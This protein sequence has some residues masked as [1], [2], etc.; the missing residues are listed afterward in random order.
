MAAARATI[1]ATP[2]AAPTRCYRS[3]GRGKIPSLPFEVRVVDARPDAGGGAV[4]REVS[5]GG[6]DKMA[7]RKTAAMARRAALAATLALALMLAPLTGRAAAGAPP[8]LRVIMLPALMPDVIA[9][10]LPIEFTPPVSGAPVLNLVAAVWCGATNNGGAD[11]IGV[12]YPA[13]APVRPAPAM[14]SEDCSRPLAEVARR[15]LA[16][17]PAPWLEAVRVR[18]TWRPWRLRL[19]LADAAGAARTGAVAPNLAAAPIAREFA[20]SNMRLLTGAGANAAFDVAIGF[21]RRAVDVVAIPAGRVSNPEPFLDDPDIAAQISGAPP[22]SNLLA[23]ATYTFI[24]QVLRLYGA[25]FPVPI[26]I[27]GVNQTMIARDLAVTGGDRFMTASGKLAYQSIEYDAAVRCEG[28]A[29]AVSKVTIDAPGATCDQ[30]DLLAR[31]RCQGGGLAMAESG[32]ALANALTNYYAGQPLRL[33]SRGNPLRFS[34]AGAEFLA[35]FDALKASSLGGTLREAGHA[36]L[37]RVSPP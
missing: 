37:R 8:P 4:G 6:R 31:M 20:T 36:R 35:T 28:D 3:R 16:G 30:S 10:A 32:G 29:L 33:S 12:V 18:A 7:Y 11:A 5:G 9:Q 26:P 22:M 24:N 19:R 27:Q 13:D 15:A 2:P 34:F 1:G 17:A 23:A 21:V 14:A 25:V